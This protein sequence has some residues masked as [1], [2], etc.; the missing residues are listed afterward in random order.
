MTWTAKDGQPVL[1]GLGEVLMLGL[2]LL[3]I[4]VVNIG[5]TTTSATVAG[6][7]DCIAFNRSALALK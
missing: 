4:K 7:T 2:A 6:N 1:L 3:D 5:Q